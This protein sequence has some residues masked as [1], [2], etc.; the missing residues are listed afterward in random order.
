MVNASRP[1]G[2]KNMN[3]FATYRR[4]R[5]MA[6]VAQC[7]NYGNLLAAHFFDK[8]FVKATFIQKKIL[9]S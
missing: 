8:N 2:Y 3:L 6:A 4:M 5:R 1:R 7:G 9:K